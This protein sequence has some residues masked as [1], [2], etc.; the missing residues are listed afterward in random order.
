MLSQN[1]CKNLVKGL[2][3]MIDKTEIENWKKVK[4]ALEKADK[5]DS[6]FY[7]RACLIIEGKS[8]PL[9]Q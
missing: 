8:D 4:E 6:F 9:K 5:T 7:K 3:K 2:P 1:I